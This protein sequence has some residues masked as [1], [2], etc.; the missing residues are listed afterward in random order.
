MD[1][2]VLQKPPRL[3]NVDVGAYDWREFDRW[4]R[5]VYDL[6]AV[7]SSSSAF[8][9]ID[10]IDAIRTISYTP[11][12]AVSTAGSDFDMSTVH[13]LGGSTITTQSDSPDA[14]LFHNFGGATTTTVTTN[15]EDYLT[16]YWMGDC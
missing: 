15:Q 14:T 7:R 10:E 1:S 9:L 13:T 6:L 5:R 2:S 11:S 8:S 16:L 3:L 12:D 4:I